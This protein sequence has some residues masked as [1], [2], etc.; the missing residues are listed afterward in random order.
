MRKTKTKA[1]DEAAQR[2]QM[3]RA[4]IKEF[5]ANNTDLYIDADKIPTEDDVNAAK[6][7]FEDA[8]KEVQSREYLIADAE[9]S[10]RV[11]KFIKDYL[12]DC[13][14]VKEYFKG[15]IN[16]N[17]HLDDFLASVEAEGPKDLVMSYAPMQFTFQILDNYA[18]RGLEDAKAFA[19][20]WDEYVAI[21]DAIRDHVE[22]YSTRNKAAETLRDRWALM[23]QG[24]Y[25]EVLEKVNPEDVMSAAEFSSSDG[26][27]EAG[28]P[29]DAE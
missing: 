29:A 28:K 2:E 11:A 21:Y 17:A 8:V 6:K 23:A 4:T 5:N 22:W 10:V 12:K 16:L 26:N 3:R 27:V 14:W 25:S 7:D 13:F 18:G 20:K 19:E 9:N 1:V 15:V 24:F